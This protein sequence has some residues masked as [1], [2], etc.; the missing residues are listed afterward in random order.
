MKYVKT[1]LNLKLKTPKD[2]CVKNKKEKEW[3]C[4]ND[5]TDVA[6]QHEHSNNKC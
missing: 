5:V 3:L 4:G 6:V 1:K 2:E